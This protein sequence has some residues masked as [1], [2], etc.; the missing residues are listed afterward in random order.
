MEHVIA[1]RILRRIHN[2][3]DLLNSR[4][5]SG[6]GSSYERTRGVS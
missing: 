2:E 6:S 1:H 3:Q 5:V 4:H